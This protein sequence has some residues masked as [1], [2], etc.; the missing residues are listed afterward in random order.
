VG[1]TGFTTFFL[2]VALAAVPWG[3][4]AA[5]VAAIAGALVAVVIA[6]RGL[7]IATRQ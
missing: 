2:V 4:L 6:S 7:R 5:F 3:M 1:L